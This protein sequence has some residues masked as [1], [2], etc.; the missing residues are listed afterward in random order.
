M[1]G[2]LWEANGHIEFQNDIA[3]RNLFLQRQFL[4][5]YT[6]AIIGKTRNR[7]EKSNKRV[8]WASHGGVMIFKW[9]QTGHATARA[10]LLGVI[11]LLR[12]RV[13]G[14]NENGGNRWCY[15][16]KAVHMVV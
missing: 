15:C 2:D 12:Q 10:I 13:R 5:F 16:R 14:V 6:V 3:E 7:P 1:F 8:V 9:V 4:S 11:S